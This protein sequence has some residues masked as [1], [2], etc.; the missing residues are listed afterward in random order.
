VLVAGGGVHKLETIGHQTGT[1]FVSLTSAELYDPA[2]GIFTATGSMNTAR[3]SHWAILL[4]NGMVLITGDALA[5]AELYDPAT[6]SFTYTGSLST[7][8]YKES[9]T[10]LDNGT[11]LV[12]G[13]VVPQTEP[14][15]V[16]NS[17]LAS[18]ELYELV[19][20]SPL[21]LSFSSQIVGTT[22]A[23][24]TFTLTNNQP[25]ALSI[26]SI[27]IGG[28]NPS[29]F[30]ESNNCIGSVSAGASC[31][32]IVTFTA[33]AAGASTGTLNITDNL[34]TIPLSLPSTGSGVIVSLAPS[35]IS[36]PAQYVGA[37]GPAQSVT[38]TNNGHALLSFTSVTTSSTDFGTVNACGSTLAVGA[39]CTISVSF[40]PTTSGTR[41][42][43][44][45]INDDAQG[46]PQTVPLSGTGQDFALGV[47]SPA[48]IT[49]SAG[50]TA[51]FSVQIWF[52]GGFNQTVQ[53]ACTGAPPLSACTATPSS[54]APNGSVDA[55]VPVS[56]TTTPAS[57][58]QLIRFPADD[59]RF[60][61]LMIELL[62]LLLL[63]GL[64]SWRRVARPQLVYGIALLVF[65]SAGMMMSAC[66]GGSSGTNKNQGT[67]VGTNLTLVVQ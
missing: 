54:V 31:S 62:A 3:S 21:S 27:V 59:Y 9:A 16:P 2:T 40:A 26:P 43:I 38:V 51:N 33:T 15:V 28:T 37:S 57:P 18:A 17:P 5:S 34:A 42:G 14:Q 22:S 53:F 19:V 67:P 12:A 39:S 55:V 7:V 52:A 23:S 13:G 63:I 47:V 46:S 56:V 30:A 64:L 41:S 20:V 65:L 11:V 60:R 25:K 44:L 66:G 32:I 6:E 24:Q 35:N 48:S 4:D 29:D 49:V 8:R 45:T 36:F 10:L 1:V 61:Y 58:A 50:Q